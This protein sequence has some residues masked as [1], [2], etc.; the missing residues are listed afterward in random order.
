MN[1]MKNSDPSTDLSSLLDMAQ[2][3]APGR[4]TRLDVR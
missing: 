1:V 2:D 4:D 3:S